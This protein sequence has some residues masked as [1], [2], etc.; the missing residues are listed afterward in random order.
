MQVLFSKKFSDSSVPLL[1][2]F[3]GLDK[4][5]VFK[6]HI[7]SFTANFLSTNVE[8]KYTKEEGWRNDKKEKAY[9]TYKKFWVASLIS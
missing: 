2:F 4:H 8:H 3:K 7:P 9:K 6:I 5:L 1:L